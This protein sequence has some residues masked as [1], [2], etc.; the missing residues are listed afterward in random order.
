[1]G[2]LSIAGSPVCT[3][4]RTWGRS[5]GGGLCKRFA[6]WL[7]WALWA[8]KLEEAVIGMSRSSRNQHMQGHSHSR[9]NLCEPAGWHLALWR[10]A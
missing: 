6:R 2:V 8:L 9:P 5:R 10:Q 1:M 3:L 7:D 4:W